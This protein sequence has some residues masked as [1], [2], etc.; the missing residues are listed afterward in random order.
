MLIL[1]VEVV[2]IILILQAFPGSWRVTV[3][4]S[5]LIILFWTLFWLL[6]VQL[7]LATISPDGTYG[8]DARYYYSEMVSSIKA[9][10]I[11]PQRGTLSPGYV[12]FG[13]IVLYTSPNVSVVWVKLANIGLLLLT[14]EI[15]FYILFLWKVSKKVAQFLIILAGTNG[16]VTWMVVRNL[17]DTMFLFLSFIVI[18][19]TKILLDSKIRNLNLSKLVLGLSL[20]AGG[21]YL[22]RLV[23]PWGYYFA[24]ATIVAVLVEFIGNYK[25]ITKSKIFGIPSLLLLILCLI[26]FS[27]LQNALKDY[28][29]LLDFAESWRYTMEFNLF[30]LVQELGRLF[31]GPGPIRP[32]FGWDVFLHTTTFGNVLITL[33][34]IVWWIY[35]PVL[36]FALIAG[37]KY[38]IEHASFLIPLL[39]F[40]F[41]YSFTYSGTAD[42]RF[43]AVIY[44]MSFILTGPYFQK[45]LKENTKEYYLRYLLASAFVWLY[46]I[47][48]SYWSM[49]ELIK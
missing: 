27:Q 16:I 41:V 12:A 44:I 19:G 38:W 33:G 37:P 29:I 46:G 22:L 26:I 25:Y 2:T 11:L 31:V 42:T 4:N 21:T 7:E 15:G 28:E 45:F 43:R 34:A 18:A 5:L 32:I 30:T 14:L 17:K 23:R 20:L 1:F 36:L 9:D 24:F 47:V 49:V 39:V 10:R 13:N 35:L 3:R 8:S 48:T 40:S 6:L